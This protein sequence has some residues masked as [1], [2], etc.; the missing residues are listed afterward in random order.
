MEVA[1]FFFLDPF[2]RTEPC[3]CR[4]FLVENGFKRAHTKKEILNADCPDELVHLGK[5]PQGAFG[6]WAGLSGKKL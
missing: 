6:K 2:L 1:S 5:S 4:F 3:F